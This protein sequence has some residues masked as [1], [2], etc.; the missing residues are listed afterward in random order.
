MSNRKL[1]CTLIESISANLTYVVS[2]WAF[3]IATTS[4]NVRKSIF[5]MRSDA[6]IPTPPLKAYDPTFE[7]P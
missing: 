5:Q 6:Y 1:I 2:V 3:R 7:F 4:A